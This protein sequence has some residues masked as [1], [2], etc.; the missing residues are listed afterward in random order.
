MECGLFMSNLI[1]GK[2][3]MARWGIGPYELLHR[4]IKKGLIAYDENGMEVSPE[5]LLGQD[6]TRDDYEK[7]KAW[8]VYELPN[9][10]A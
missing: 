5:A 8:S 6:D 2:D 3:L 9:S 4:F 1:S 7:I 10:E